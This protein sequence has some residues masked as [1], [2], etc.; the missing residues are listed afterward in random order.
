[1]AVND[2]GKIV[3]GTGENSEGIPFL[4]IRNYWRKNISDD[5]AP[6]KGVRIHSKDLINGFR[7]QLDVAI[8]KMGL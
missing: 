6:G 5:F 8:E 7:D 3:F 1:L 2:F 4:D